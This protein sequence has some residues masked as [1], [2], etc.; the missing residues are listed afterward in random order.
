MAEHLLRRS[1]THSVRHLQAHLLQQIDNTNNLLCYLCGNGKRYLMEQM[2]TDV[3]KSH[4][5]VRI[6]FKPFLLLLKVWDGEERRKCWNLYQSSTGLP[7][8]ASLHNILKTLCSH[9]PIASKGRESNKKISASQ[10]WRTIF[11]HFSFGPS[12][13]QIKNKIMFALFW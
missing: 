4:R 10:L 1:R 11:V 13:E 2:F 8:L 6:T 12:N 9:L 5:T 7:L 3:K